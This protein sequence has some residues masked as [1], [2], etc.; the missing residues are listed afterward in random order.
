MHF[1]KRQPLTFKPPSLSQYL[2]I[3]SY[4]ESCLQNNNNY[5]IRCVTLY[6]GISRHFLAA[7]LVDNNFWQPVKNLSN[8]EKRGTFCTSV[9]TTLYVIVKLDRPF[10]FNMDFAVISKKCHSE[11]SK[12][13]HIIYTIQTLIIIITLPKE[14]F[15][16]TIIINY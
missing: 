2:I 10:C 4:Y 1:F 8:S 15:S 5:H 13:L 12:F 11:V 16:A 9:P 14:G 3:L 7:S 6:R